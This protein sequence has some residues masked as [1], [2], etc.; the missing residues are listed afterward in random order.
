MVYPDLRRY[1]LFAHLWIPMLQQIPY[2]S[3][4]VAGRR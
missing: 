3:V 2:L 4:V 1:N